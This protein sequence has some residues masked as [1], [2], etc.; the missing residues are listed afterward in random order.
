MRCLSWNVAALFCVLFSMSAS[1]EGR[2][3]LQVFFN[4]NSN[5]NYLDPYREFERTGDNFEEV[6]LE[7]IDSAKSEIL[8]AVQ[9]FR[10]PYV[11]EALPKNVITRLLKL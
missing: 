7:A 3:N 6:V 9:E 5:E 8:I 4:H 2:K 1:A 10:L 11:A